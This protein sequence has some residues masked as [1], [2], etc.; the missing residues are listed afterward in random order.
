VVHP[1]APPETGRETKSLLLGEVPFSEQRR[2]VDSDLYA[3]YAVVPQGF[4][5]QFVRR[6][7]I[8][9]GYL[10]IYISLIVHPLVH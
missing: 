9:F 8:S 3:L 7:M 4:S 10:F 5:I 1:L 2:K 6:R